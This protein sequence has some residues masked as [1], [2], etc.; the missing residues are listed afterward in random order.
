MRSAQVKGSSPPVY[1][2]SGVAWLP[3]GFL[4]AVRRADLNIFPCYLLLPDNL[5][6]GF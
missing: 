1:L 5:I 2:N 6:T 3:D 4:S